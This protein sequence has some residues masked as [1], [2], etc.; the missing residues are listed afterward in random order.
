MQTIIDKTTAARQ[1]FLPLA[2]PY[3][4]ET[5]RTAFLP[6]VTA[7]LSKGGIPFRLVRAGQIGIEVWRT[8]KGY[9]KDKNHNHLFR[10]AA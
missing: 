5:E 6:R 10:A 8:K 4:T 7:D 2:G 9:R 3:V 1:G